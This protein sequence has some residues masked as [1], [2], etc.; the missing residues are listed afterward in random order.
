M[1]YTGSQAQAGRGSSL[2]IGSTP[3]LIG[4]IKEVP[5]NR[6]KWELIDT[7]NF[8]SGSDSEQLVTI[9]K[10]G[11][12]NFKGNR[13]SSDA[14][15]V[16]VE[17]AYQA[18]TLVAFV[19]QLPKTATQTTAGDKYTFNAFVVGSDFTDAVTAAVEFSIELQISGAC[20]LTVGS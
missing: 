18:G 17:T 16:A 7:T 13:V 3:T 2:S 5:L 4:E 14:G 9:R 20:T 8:E 19:L 1:P 12:V 10:P 15:Q 6:G 11:T